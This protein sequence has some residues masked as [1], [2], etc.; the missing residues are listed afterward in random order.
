M[1]ITAA[2][3]ETIAP[4]TEHNGWTISRNRITGRI[5]ATVTYSNGTT[6]KLSC[7]PDINADELMAKITAAVG[8]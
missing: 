8:N 6:A 4:R 5:T 7:S 3:R 2:V 1:N